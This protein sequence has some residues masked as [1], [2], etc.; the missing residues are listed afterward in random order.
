MH[1]LRKVP[2]AQQWAPRASAALL[3]DLCALWGSGEGISHRPRLCTS[4]REQTATVFTGHQQEMPRGT[5]AAA[6]SVPP[7]EDGVGRGVGRSRQA[8]P[9]PTQ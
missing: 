4:S 2:N 1:S 7:A 8:A 3:L 9:D 5:D 6:K